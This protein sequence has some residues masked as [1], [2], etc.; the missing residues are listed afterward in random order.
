MFPGIGPITDIVNGTTSFPVTPSIVFP[1]NTNTTTYVK[2][3][4]PFS[5]WTAQLEKN[6]QAMVPPGTAGVQITSLTPIIGVPAGGTAITIN[7]T[8]F[9]GTT[10]VNFGATPGTSLTVVSNTQITVTSP[11]GTTHTTVTLTIVNATN[12][13][14]VLYNGFSYS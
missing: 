1:N 9:T 13:N 4:D 6:L 14:G 3:S 8:G 10:A 2:P 12:G 5:G 11:A 7:G